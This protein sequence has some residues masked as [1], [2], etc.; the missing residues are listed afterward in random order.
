MTLTVG[1]APDTVAVPPLEGLTVS[2]AQAE[3]EA[4]DL[5]LG[6]RLEEASIEFDVGEII[7]SDPPADA[8]VEPG[9]AIDVYVSTGPETVIVPD[10]STGCLSRGGANKILRDAELVLELGEAVP[11]TPECPNPNRIIGQEPL[12][13]ETVEAGSVVTVFPGGGGD[14]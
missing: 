8:D 10:V 9:T 3:L 4:K 13:G 12:A 11:S 5:T 2:E 7:R 1:I 14:V 6:S